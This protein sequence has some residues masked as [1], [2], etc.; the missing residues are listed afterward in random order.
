MG[1]LK[2]ETAIYTNAGSQFASN[3]QDNPS[4]LMQ[5]LILRICLLQKLFSEEITTYTSI[6]SG[7]HS[8]YFLLDDKFRQLKSGNSDIILWKIPSVKFVFDSAKVSRLSSNP[9][10]EPDMSFGSLAFRIHPHDYNFLSI[11]TLMVLDLL[12]GSVHQFFSPSSQATMTSCYDGPSQ[13]SSTLVFVTN[14]TH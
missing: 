9:I 13:K 8:Q 3:T 12:P 7:I 14:R 5:N 4:S 11:Y 1:P 6:T 10:I 2:A